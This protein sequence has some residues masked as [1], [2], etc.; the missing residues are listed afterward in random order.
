MKQIIIGDIIYQ[1]TPEK[2]RRLKVALQDTNR[3]IAVHMR[4]RPEDRDQTYLQN[5]NRHARDLEILLGGVE[6]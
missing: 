3:A 6:E 1:L 5:L 4:R 2:E